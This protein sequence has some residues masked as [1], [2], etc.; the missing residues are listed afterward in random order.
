MTVRFA[1]DL[2]GY[3]WLFPRPDHVGV[4]ICAPLQSSPTRTLNERLEAEVSR[5][6]PGLRHGRRY[7]HTI[8]SP[9]EDASSLREIAGDHWALVGD[10]AALADPITGE[11]I[12]YALRSAELLSETLA[13]DAALARYPGRVLE[14]FGHDLLKAASLR[15]R[16][17]TP[18]F[19]RRMIRYSATSAAVRD[20]LGD[21][22]LGD[23]GYVGLKRR[24]LRTFPRFAFEWATARRR[25]GAVH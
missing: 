1:S 7:A 25:P 4:G 19:A 17:Y 15:A 5:S 22:V 13:A 12:Y 6:F 16:F 2:R 23:Q 8:P 24:L 9:S 18:G 14:D 20:V 10:A 11:G 3:L 21:L